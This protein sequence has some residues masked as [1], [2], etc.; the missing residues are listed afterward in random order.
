M[1][2]PEI[3][4]LTTAS[5]VECRSVQGKPMIIQGY[6]AV[7]DSFSKP[8][9]LQGVKERVASSFFN[10]QRGDNNFADVLVRYEHRAD[11]LLGKVG[12]G[13]TAEVRSGGL[14]YSV[15]IN[16]ETRS[17]TDVYEWVKAGI[18][19]GSSF[20]FNVYQD[21]WDW[22][23]GATCRTLLSG[24]TIDLGP[25]ATPAYESSS[26]VALRSLA[27][28]RGADFDEVRSLAAQGELRKLWVRTDN[29]ESR[30]EAL[31]EDTGMYA[32]EALARLE[33]TNPDRTGP[34]ARERQL[35]LLE[36][37]ASWD[38]EYEQPVSI[39]EARSHLADMAAGWSAPL[40]ENQRAAWHHG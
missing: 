18:V 34:S 7:F 17:G 28:H 23:N 19:A 29:I 31:R 32:H 14:W 25:T 13:A 3:E 12:A 26:A 11:F 16:P 1:R 33:Q 40:S 36:L 2:S 24:K 27:V 38:Q 8:L 10:K 5:P 35:Q 39:A 15:D 9:G 37:R 22:Q 30:P 6:A 4:T 20:S 21:D